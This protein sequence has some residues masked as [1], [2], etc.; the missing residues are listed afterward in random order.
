MILES[1]KQIQGIQVFDIPSYIQSEIDGWVKESR[2]WKD[3]PLGELKAHENAGYV[4]DNGNKYNSY[5]CCIS[6]RL[7]E[8]SLW[9]SWVLRLAQKYF[10]QDVHHRALRVYKMDG[11]WDGYEVWTNFSYMGDQNPPHDHT[12][13]YL[14]GIIYYSNHGHPTYFDDLDVSYE[15]KDGTMILFPAEETHSVA[16]QFMDEERITIAFNIDRNWEWQ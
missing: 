15:G 5:Q 7:I 3:H 12:G 4:L 16:E 1:K 10:A 6:P 11:H 8:E 13:R 14:S 2:K 9:M